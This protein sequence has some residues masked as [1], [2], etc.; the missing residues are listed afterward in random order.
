MFEF[1]FFIAS[2]LPLRTLLKMS[3]PFTGV[4]IYILEVRVLKYVL[5]YLVNVP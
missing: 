4:E 5:Y 1:G 3:R 2:C